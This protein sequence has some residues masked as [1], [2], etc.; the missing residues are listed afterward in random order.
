MLGDPELATLKKGDTV[1]LQR[2]GFYICDSAYEFPSRHSGRASPCILIN[3]PDGHTKDMHM[4]GSK[5][6]DAK[7]E[8]SA[9]EVGGALNSQLLKSIKYSL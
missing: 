9:K 1:Q 7:Q 4:A 2:R 5:H 3:I 6:K 8:P